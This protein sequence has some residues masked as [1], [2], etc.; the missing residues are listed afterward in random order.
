MRKVTNKLV[1]KFREYL[2]EEEKSNATVSKYVSGLAFITVKSVNEG[3]VTVYCKG[4]ERQILIPK[5]LQIKLLYYIHMLLFRH[6]SPI[7]S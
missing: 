3:I 6:I 5:A 7:F 2:Y 1:E 4:K